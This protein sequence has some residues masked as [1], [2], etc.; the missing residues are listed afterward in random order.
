VIF[1]FYRLFINSVIHKFLGEH[2]QRMHTLTYI[3]AH[4]HT[5]T[6]TP[7]IFCESWTEKMKGIWA[8][9]NIGKKDTHTKKAVQKKQKYYIREFVS[10]FGC[11]PK[12]QLILP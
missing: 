5:H 11:L 4:T 9:I 1:L 10:T 12:R 8:Q 7:Q 3:Y 2:E 6:H